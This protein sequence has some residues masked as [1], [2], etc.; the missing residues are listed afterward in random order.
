MYQVLKSELPELEKRIR[1]IVKKLNKYGLTHRFEILGETVKEVNVYR[2]IVG[3]GQSG[4]EQTTEKLGTI[5]EDVVEYIFE[6]EELKVGDYLPIAVITHGALT[7]NGET[8]NMVHMIANDEET[9][10]EWWTADST[11]KHCNRKRSRNKTVIL[12]NTTGQYTQVGTTC[13]KDYTG[14]DAQDIIKM[15]ADVQDVFLTEA[16]YSV[17][18]GFPKSGYV[19]TVNYL[20]NTIACIERDGYR[21]SDEKDSTKGVAYQVTIDR[22]SIAANHIVEAQ[23]IIDFYSKLSDE[24]IESFNSNVKS[25]LACKYSKQ[26]GILAYAPIAYKT[27]KKRL[28]EVA[29]HRA[30]AANSQFVGEVGKRYTFTL[31]HENTFSFNGE[32][33]TQFIHLFKDESGNTFKWSTANRIDAVSTLTL[34]G[35]IKAHDVYRDEKQTVITRCKIV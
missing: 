30:V 9:N 11:C 28:E 27:T 29:K 16:R 14:I 34:T 10:P 18:E 6:M 7:E 12:K 1:G 31:Q 17:T 4:M 32:Y 2:T 22:N 3:M 21:K 33:G 8:R 23:E 15:Y 13:I 26:S 35:T 19:P 25:V 20:A 24:D 5:V